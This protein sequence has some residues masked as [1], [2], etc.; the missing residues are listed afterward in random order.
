[1]LIN[2]KKPG[3]PQEGSNHKAHA[4]DTANFGKGNIYNESE[5]CLH[6]ADCRDVYCGTHDDFWQRVS[7]DGR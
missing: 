1:M 2:I 6:I 5:I 3:A 4:P 7:H